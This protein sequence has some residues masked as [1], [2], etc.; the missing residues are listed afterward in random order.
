MLGEN[1]RSS[2]LDKLKQL[3]LKMLEAE[4]ESLDTKEFVPDLN[5]LENSEDSIEHKQENQGDAAEDLVEAFIEEENTPEALPKSGSEGFSQPE[6]A[7]QRYPFVVPN[8]GFR[9]GEIK[10]AEEVPVVGQEKRPRI[11]VK[12]FKYEGTGVGGKDPEFKYESNQFEKY[13]KQKTQVKL[14]QPDPSVS[15]LIEASIEAKYKKPTSPLPEGVTPIKP[16]DEVLVAEKEILTPKE[17][18]TASETTEKTPEPNLS[19]GKYKETKIGFRKDYFSADK[20]QEEKPKTLPLVV[21]EEIKPQEK[22]LDQK[23]FEFAGRVLANQGWEFSPEEQEFYDKNESAIT[24]S[25]IE[26]NNKASKNSTNAEDKKLETAKTIEV[27]P[28]TPLSKA[29]KPKPVEMTRSKLEALNVLDLKKKEKE[30]G[31]LKELRSVREKREAEER[32]DKNIDVKSIKIDG[33]NQFQLEKMNLSLQDIAREVPNFLELSKGQQR[34]IIAKLKERIDSTIG[35]KTE[36]GVANSTKNKKSILGRFTQSVKNNL[37]FG[38]SRLKGLVRSELYENSFKYFGDDLKQ[39]TGFVENRGYEIESNGEGFVTRFINKES[40]DSNHRKAINEFNKSASGLSETPASWMQPTASNSEKKAVKKAQKRYEEAKAN[41]ISI[42]KKIAESQ[43]T[44]KG[45]SGKMEMRNAENKILFEMANL[46]SEVRMSQ[47]LTSEPELENRVANFIKGSKLEEKSIIA[48]AGAL[49]K[50]VGKYAFGFG[51]GV[52]ASSIIGG[53]VANRRTKEKFRQNE[54]MQSAGY[55]VSKE[56]LREKINAESYTNKINEVI[57]KI[58]KQ[59]TTSK[60]REWVQNLKTRVDIVMARAD[61]ALIDWGRDSKQLKNKTELFDAVEKANGYI[62]QHDFLDDDKVKEVYARFER[63]FL[64]DEDKDEE[65]REEIVRQTENGVLLGAGLFTVGWL[66]RDLT[67]S[68]LVVRDSYKTNLDNL[69]KDTS[70]VVIPSA[71]TPEVENV[72]AVRESVKIPVQSEVT[73]IKVEEN[74]S[75]QPTQ[76]ASDV[77]NMSTE[78]S[79]IEK[80]EP[81]NYESDFNEVEAGGKVELN[82]K[83]LSGDVMFTYNADGKVEDVDISRVKSDDVI[84]FRQNPGNFME[85]DLANS[86]L[87]FPTRSYGVNTLTRL[88]EN[89]EEALIY[90][91]IL[92]N[93]NL[94]PQS[95]EYLL[96]ETKARAAEG[97]MEE[98]SGGIFRPTYEEYIPNEESTVPK[99]GVVFDQKSGTFVK[100]PSVEEVV[101]TENVPVKPV[102]ASE[103]NISVPKEEVKIEP[104]K[105][106]ASVPVEDKPSGTVEVISSTPEEKILDFNTDEVKGKVK[107]VYDKKGI[108]KQVSLSDRATI[109]GSDDIKSVLSENWRQKA[110]RYSLDQRTGQLKV[111]SDIKNMIK[112]QKILNTGEFATDSPEYKFLKGQIDQVLRTYRDVLKR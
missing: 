42:E 54:R 24:A 11:E 82:E 22:T 75:M 44:T 8:P 83:G 72:E 25:I 10:P 95:P 73:P 57:G 103:E 27:K 35:F 15:R 105:E 67:Q 89:A 26:Q 88:R 2:D 47:F 55:N 69:S 3:Q 110:G 31:I 65:R 36:E 71:S 68:D 76:E 59:T 97:L 19:S 16:I 43:I 87:K 91:N 94:N 60:R 18:I 61:E 21:A 6:G 90:K 37:F 40:V 51:G 74:Y 32:G 56:G 111:E 92:E 93:G 4:A 84:R 79:D 9:S 66:V 53:I 49:A 1:L 7:V 33:L 45:D 46:N 52:L 23:V 102:E 34:Y 13:M 109:K 85:K 112:L 100:A 98:K 104:V 50:G 29:E 108:L 80:S 99:S 5:V 14:S 63:R 86:D 62:Y 64:K 101:K 96:I 41:L 17:Q 39:L 12:K 106:A 107:L 38:K 28:E 77:S 30:S 70:G 58:E 78:I 81:L 48:G 20:M